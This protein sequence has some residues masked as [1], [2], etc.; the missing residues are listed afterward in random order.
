MLAK[1]NV[2]E[3]AMAVETDNLVHGRTNNPF[4]L[5]RT[6]GGSS[7]GPAAAV[8]A[9]LSPLD[10][11]SDGGGSI[12]LPAHYCGVAALKATSGRISLAGHFPEPHGSSSRILATGPIARS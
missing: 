7:G 3:F 11:G 9:G 6:C 12:R 8:A 5:D 2:P 4:G 1:T 10:V